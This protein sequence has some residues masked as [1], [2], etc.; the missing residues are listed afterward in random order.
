[1]PLPQPEQHESK[2]SYIARA[3]AFLEAD[4]K[5]KS[6]KD[7]RSH[8]QIVAIAESSWESSRKTDKAARIIEELN[9]VKA[10]LIQ[11]FGDRGKQLFEHTMRTLGYADGQYNT[12]S[13]ADLPVEA[14]PF[15]KEDANG[16]T[17]GNIV[18]SEVAFSKIDE[19]AHTVEGYANTVVA[20]TYRDVVLPV[21]YEDSVKDYPGDVYILHRKEVH[22][23]RIVESHVDDIGWYVKSKPDA[24][25]WPMIQSKK[26]RGYSIG[27]SFFFGKK[28]GDA[29]VY[30]E[31]YSTYIDDLSYV[32]SPANKL[33]FFDS[34]KTKQES[35]ILETP[36]LQ[37]Q[38]TVH[39]DAKIV[40]R[41]DAKSSTKNKTQESK[42]MSET[43]KT[44]SKQESKSIY[45]MTP[46]QIVE[47]LKEQ[48]KED[49]RKELVKKAE[50]II[51]K[52]KV[53]DEDTFKKQTLEAFGKI[54]ARLDE[55]SGKLETLFAKSAIHD[56][57]FVKMEDA[58]EEH[59]ATAA[60]AGINLALQAVTSKHGI[61]AQ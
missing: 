24:D 51:E 60:P 10:A 11:R 17:V 46:D 53:E 43:P 50:I 48:A 41:N 28:V 55:F 59:A 38:Q 30:D 1:M 13:C 31:P 57:K 47:F 15:I 12:F 33:S 2:D 5:R 4:N 26:Y 39:K 54:N 42:T 23:G 9:R 34:A 19:A 37:S 32:S 21:S 40:V 8:S 7:Q 36:I 27:G 45:D 29:Q 35:P 49:Y 61:G 52:R 18:L 3:V 22:G 56:E 20:D 16:V 25:V 14:F 6:A 58:P 44:D